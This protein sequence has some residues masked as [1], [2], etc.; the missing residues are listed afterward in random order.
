MVMALF[1]LFSFVFFDRHIKMEKKKVR[2]ILLYEFKMET[3]CN[4][5]QT[6]DQGT[7]NGRTAQHWSQNIRNGDQGFEEVED[8]GSLSAVHAN[9]VRAITESDPRKTSREVAEEINVHR[10]AIVRRLH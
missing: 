1:S 8:G 5:N 6:R 2:A 9:Q 7:V 4:I 10:S 3:A